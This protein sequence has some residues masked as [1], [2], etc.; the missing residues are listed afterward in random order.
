MYLK[1]VRPVN[2]AMAN[3]RSTQSQAAKAA[4]CPANPD[5][6]VLPASPVA[7]A[8]PVHPANQ[9]TPANLQLPHARP[10]PHHHANLAHKDLPAH[11]DHPDLPETPERLVP[12]ADPDTMP[13]PEPP[14]PEDHPDLPEKP[15][16][17]DHPE[18]PDNPPLPSHS[19][20]EPPEKPETSD[21][22]DLP[23]HPDNPVWTAHLDLPARKESPARPES[24]EP[25]ATPDQP[26]PP[27][28]PERPERKVSARNTAP[29]T[30]ECSSRT[31]LADKKFANRV[32]AFSPT[33]SAKHP[34]QGVFSTYADINN[35]KNYGVDDVSP[36]VVSVFVY[37]ILCTI[38]SCL[39]YLSI[40]HQTPVG[41]AFSNA[42]IFN[43]FT[44]TS[45]FI[46][47]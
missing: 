2:P 47:S 11:P 30:E 41:F 18:R 4:A 3:R 36:Y 37:L 26:D 43:I 1:I 45:L 24:P 44:H 14:D 29:S 16:Q 31:E 15:D 20:P 21:P 33:F 19:L 12:P 32:S 46:Y 22:L 10:P 39:H 34:G 42:K 28:Q 35:I 5:P 8:N 17:L 13:H 27:A 23:A 25:T 7:P 40:C 38:F 6:K 9:A